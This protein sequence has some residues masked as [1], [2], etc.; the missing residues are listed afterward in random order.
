[1]RPTKLTDDVAD[2]I[3]AARRKGLTDVAICRLVGIH[4]TSLV[5]WKH[6]GEQAKSGRFFEFFIAYQA[7]GE[8]LAEILMDSAVR[9]A[10]TRRYEYEVLQEEIT[11]NAGKVTG[12]KIKTKRKAIPADGGL[13][14]RLLERRER[15]EWGPRHI[16]PSEQ[17]SDE[18][19]PGRVQIEFIK[20][21]ERDA[22]GNEILNDKD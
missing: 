20:P 6:R 19:L 11:D 21:P 7:A 22:D 1:M 8:H 17:E 14:L 10:T 4:P 15:W 18:A 3:I 16:D 5:N 12:Y 9:A 13:A 2:A